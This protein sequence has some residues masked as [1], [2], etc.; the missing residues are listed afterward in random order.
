MALLS[1]L[2]QLAF[3]QFF[4]FGERVPVSID[5]NPS[6]LWKLAYHFPPTGEFHVLN[7]LGQA[8]YPQNL[9]PLSLAA[10]DLPPWWFFTTYAPLM[11]TFALL[12]MTAFL[13]ELELPRPAAI[14]GGVIYAW[15]GDIMPF[16]YPG[17]Y[18]YITMWP[19]FALAAWGAL[20][21]ERTG[22]W[23]YAV[24]SGASCGIMVGL[25]T[26]ADRGGIACLFVAALYLAAIY[27]RQPIGPRFN[28]YLAAVRPLVLCVIVAA[29]I[30]LAPLLA[31]FKGNVEG[32]KL[33]GID[34]REQTY[35][36][37][38]QFSLG[39]ADTLTYLVPGLFGW[40]SSNADGPYWG[41]I[42]ETS[43]WPKHHQGSRN[44]NLAITTTGTIA[45]VLALLAT[46]L[47]VWDGLLGSALTTSRQLFY[48]RLLLALGSLAL[49][50]SWGWH[51]PFYRPLFALPLMDKWR[52]PLKWAEVTNFA[53]VVLS[54]IGLQHLLASLGT[55]SADVK[56][57]RSRLATFTLAAAMLLGLGWAITYP[58]ALRLPGILQTEDYDPTSVAAIMSLFHTAA[59]VAFVEMVLLGMVLR[60]LWSPEF[61]RRWKPVNPLVQ[62]GWQFVLLPQNLPATLAIV[63]AGLSAA[64][65]GWVANHFLEPI[66]IKG[67]T[68]TNP[69]L[70]ALRS[71]GDTVRCSAAAQD[72]VLNNLM[73]NQFE[74]M[75]ISCID[76]SAASRIPDLLNSFFQTL[77]SEQAQMWFLAGVKNVVVPE[78]GLQQMR[79]DPGVAANIDHAVGFTLAPTASP[80]IPSHAMVTMKQYLAKATLVPDAEIF[81]S[82]EAVL[83][84]LKDLKWNPWQSVLL[85]PSHPLPEI[86]VPSGIKVGTDEVGLIVYTPTA[87]E[88]K[89]RSARGGY[90]LVNDQYDPDWSAQVDGRDVE[91]LRADYIMRA[92]QVPAGESTVTMKYIAH[93]HLAG[94]SPNARAVNNFSDAAMLASWLAAAFALRRQRTRARDGGEQALPVV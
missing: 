6:V 9:Q 15:Q 58:L 30:A 28:A 7:W 80:D 22:L 8:F 34:D 2:V 27:R 54:A 4:T 11:A 67:L 86:K 5:I 16:V 73:Q 69:L 90:V 32:V 59:L 47:L 82:D 64:Q 31:L 37:V 72:P 88:I 46:L 61:L 10:T 45:S 71:E 78:A 84:R 57:I 35:Q 23:A 33:G 36:F 94:F 40:H 77:D 42:G 75:N 55:E 25:P 41:W 50:L 12:A 26:N 13:R 29:I 19:F 44:F 85:C 93:Y 3:C 20:R 65:L 43:D 89:V 21:C 68:D 91:L 14:F 66:S 18:A 74:A 87:I 60:F 24:I 83:A 38:T 48:G 39:P 49:V 56:V 53:I 70:D 51:T 1:L 52:D 63:L 17:H 92:V 81:T 62:Q 76:V 79:Q